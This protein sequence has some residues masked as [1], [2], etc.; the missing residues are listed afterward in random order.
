MLY[1]WPCALNICTDNN[2]RV[3]PG[4]YSEAGAIDSRSVLG[5]AARRIV[6]VGGF[7][8]R[9]FAVRRFAVRW[10]LV[11]RFGVRRLERAGG[12][13]LGGG[14]DAHVRG[15]RIALGGVGGEVGGGLGGDLEEG[16]VARDA[17]GADLAP[18]DGA[19]AANQRQDPVGLGAILGAE[20]DLEQHHL[21]RRRRRARRRHRLD[22]DRRERLAGRPLGERAIDQRGDDGGRVVLGEELRGQH[23]RGVA[24]RRGGG[25]A[26]L[27]AHALAIV[28]RDRGGARRG[29]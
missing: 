11:R 20:V 13:G 6:A 10:S 17:D 2:R 14:L 27:D 25:G 1:R 29:G 22:V 21:A 8:V 18:R 15:A 28:R 23:A 5:L 4:P 16:A 24:R 12:H 7:V 26:Q 9:R 19:A 3:K